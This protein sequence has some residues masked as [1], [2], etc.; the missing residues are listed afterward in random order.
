ME[1]NE[2]KTLS[3]NVTDT[4]LRS[5]KVIV[6]II[7]V[8]ITFAIIAAVFLTVRSAKVK[9]G[10]EQLDAIELRYESLEKDSD[11]YAIEVEAVLSDAEILSED[12]SGVVLVRTSMLMA[13]INFELENWSSAR[14]LYLSAYE[15]DSEAYSAPLNLYNAAVSSEELGD[16]DA[17]IE[18]F[19]KA[20][21]FENFALS[22][23]A[24]F[25]A[26]RIEELNGDFQVAHDRYVLINDTHA[27]TEWAS[28]AKSRIIYLKAENKAQ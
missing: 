28:L 6:T 1:S 26:A 9:D 22:A 2:K 10:L 13:E 17:A 11:S 25:N 23:R 15:A 18:Y 16:L 3:A 24:M 8:T 14:E 4:I 7:I 12:F 21:A 19:D 20:A 27:T 5:R